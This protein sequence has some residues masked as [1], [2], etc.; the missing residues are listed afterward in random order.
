MNERRT[1]QINK[2]LHTELSGILQRNFYGEFK[3]ALI[4]ITEASISP[5][6]SYAKIYISIFNFDKPNE[7]VDYLNSHQKNIRG[8]L[9]NKISKQVRKIPELTFFVDDSVEKIFKLDQHFKD[10]RK[11]D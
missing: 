9:G 2:L 1:H 6:M 7:V 11:E 10:N 4:S 8:I 3:G 5:D